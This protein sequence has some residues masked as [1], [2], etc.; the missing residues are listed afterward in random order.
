MIREMLRESAG[1]GPDVVSLKEID[2]MPNQER[3]QVLFERLTIASLDALLANGGALN[4]KAGR[5]HSP[6]RK[7][8]KYQEF[9]NPS[10]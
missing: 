7:R 3:L 10:A 6:K 9:D 5:P 8:G 4:G 1:R 2:L